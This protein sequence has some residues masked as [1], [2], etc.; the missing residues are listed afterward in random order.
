MVELHRAIPDV[1]RVYDFRVFYGAGLY[2]LIRVFDLPTYH[3]A[4]GSVLLDDRPLALHDPYDDTLPT[5]SSMFWAQDTLTISCIADPR[6]LADHPQ[7]HLVN[8][9]LMRG[10]IPLHKLFTLTYVSHRRSA[11]HF[12]AGRSADSKVGFVCYAVGCPSGEPYETELGVWE[13]GRDGEFQFQSARKRVDHFVSRRR[14][15]PLST[16]YLTHTDLTIRTLL[17]LVPGRI[18]NTRTSH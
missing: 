1:M 17:R 4:S 11:Y 5:T 10:T 18:L 3:S 14:R 15:R 13:Y 16:S 2:E 6:C 7:A 12:L 8:D 9:P